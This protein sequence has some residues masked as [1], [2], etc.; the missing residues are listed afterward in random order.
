MS[1]LNKT[2]LPYF[3]LGIGLFMIF[4]GG[5]SLFIAELKQ[6]HEEVNK[7]QVNVKEIYNTFSH[8][9]E[10]FES[11]RDNLYGGILGEMYFDQLA[12]GD[13]IIRE[14]L[15]NYAAIVDEIEK[16]VKTLNELCTDMY[17]SEAAVNKMCSNYK[18]IYEQV[19]NCLVKDISAYNDNVK[20]FN[21]NNVNQI[22]IY[23]LDR[24]YIDYNKDKNF[25]GK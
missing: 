20:T 15:D 14:S 7:R 5:G 8:N 2:K 23:K 13:E 22:N 3:L 25:D 17:Y 1:L 19:N 12:E 4:G 6:D 24:K 18:I 10:L 16:K 21:M 11:E 9:V